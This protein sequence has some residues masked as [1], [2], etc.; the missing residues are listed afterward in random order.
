MLG[1]V[2]RQA[3]SFNCPY[4]SNSLNCALVRSVLKYAVEVWSPSSA[5]DIKRR[6]SIKKQFLIFALRNINWKLSICSTPYQDRL[7]LLGMNTLKESKDDRRSLAS[8]LLV[9]DSLKWNSNVLEF[10]NLFR[11]REHPRSTL[12]AS[13]NHVET[14]KSN[15]SYHFNSV[16]S[17]SCIKTF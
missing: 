3:K 14:Y 17:R 9:F 6:E 10:F 13:A 5:S 8:C 16:V 11:P 4:V 15:C 2:K 1:F 7:K 12:I